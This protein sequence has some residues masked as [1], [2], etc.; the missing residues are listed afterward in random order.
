MRVIRF[1]DAS[2]Q[3]RLGEWLADG[4]AQV[5]RGGLFDGLERTDEIVSVRRL[6][7]PLDPVDVIAIG[8]NYKK[9]AE[10]SGATIP[11]APLVF[12]KLTSSVIGPGDAIVLPEDAPDEVDYEAELAVVIGKTARKVRP[13]VALN[14]V[15]GYTCANDVSAR[16]CQRFRDKQWTRAKSFDTFC[17]L[18]PA[19]LVDPAVN[20]NAL[21]IVGRLNGEVVQ[22]SN[23]A[24][25]IFSVPFLVSYLSQHFT[26]RP[27]TVILTGTPEGVG[28]GKTP[29]RY[30]R[31]GETF[32]V[33][34]E[35]IGELK[36]PV[37]R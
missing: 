21:Q 17:P 31:A 25:M 24:D 26:L 33:E 18:G 1:E 23:T 8:L 10:E 2:G 34:I 37:T 35:G 7:A 32:S 12:A 11:D 15:L 19:I 6:L 27:G 30:M 29:P 20:P 4:R 14:Y 9:H 13:D 16:D 3:V 22:N 5:I 36:N 28:F